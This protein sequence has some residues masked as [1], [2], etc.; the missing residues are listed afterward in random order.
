[1]IVHTKSMHFFQTGTTT[2][3]KYSSTRSGYSENIIFDEIFRCALGNAGTVQ[4]LHR[5][6]RVQGCC[7]RRSTALRR[8]VLDHLKRAIEGFRMLP[9]VS[10]SYEI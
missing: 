10:A 7:G 5:T 1:M 3:L 9:C 2:I 4:G 8:R 6:H